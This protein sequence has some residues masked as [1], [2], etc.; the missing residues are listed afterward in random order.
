MKKF[1]IRYKKYFF[2]L[3]AVLITGYYFCLP[4]N[5][6]QD[7]YSTV[8][9]D[10]QGELLA[11]SIAADGQWRFPVLDTV[12]EKFAQALVAYEDKRFW[13]HPGVDIRS[14]GRA[15]KQNIKAGEILSGGSTITMQVIR[16]SRKGKGRTIL[17]KMIESVLATRLELRSSKEEVLALYA[18]H[19]PFGGNVVGLEAACWRYFA[20]EP[21]ELSWAEAA[22]LAVLPNSPSLIHPGKNREKLLLKR[23]RL[24]AKLNATKVI[25]QF[26]YDLALLEPIPV[27]PHVLPRHA[28]HLL[29]QYSLRYSKGWSR[30]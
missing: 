13:N 24:L 8:L 17:E 12:P 27:E 30:F 19:A 23:N 22:M 25:D 2:G 6:F 29:T 15:I 3:I 18:S 21:K 9:E 5:L 14:I 16:L 11:A 1:F 10:H 26:T 28:R 4:S 20:C 7:P